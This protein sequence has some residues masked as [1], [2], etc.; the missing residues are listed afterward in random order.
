ML[1]REFGMIYLSATQTVVIFQNGFGIRP[2]ICVNFVG[3]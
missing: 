3:L 1:A 2:W